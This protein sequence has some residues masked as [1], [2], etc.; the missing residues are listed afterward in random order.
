MKLAQVLQPAIEYAERGFP[1][2]DVIAADW[3]TG[4]RKDN[5]HFAATY[6]PGEVRRAKSS[7]TR[8]WRTR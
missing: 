8:I 1:V 7:S 4:L 6:L 3:Q 5:P 2:T